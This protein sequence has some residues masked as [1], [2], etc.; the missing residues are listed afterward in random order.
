[1]GPLSLQE[2]ER[3]QKYYKIVGKRKECKI[4]KKSLAQRLKKGNED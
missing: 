3:K 4:A 1:V 2:K